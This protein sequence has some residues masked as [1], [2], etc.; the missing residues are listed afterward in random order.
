M[1]DKESFQESLL[2]DLASTKKFLQNLLVQT[3]E[4]DRKAAV[5]E[6]ELM[7]KIHP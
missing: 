3:A 6:K 2:A 5:E 1:E 4:Q 7:E